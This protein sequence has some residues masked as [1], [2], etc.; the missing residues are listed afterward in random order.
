MT[1]HTQKG[2]KVLNIMRVTIAATAVISTTLFGFAIGEP[3]LGLL[4]LAG[5]IL[6]LKADWSR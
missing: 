2:I 6:F 5:A 3:T 4:A 1:Y